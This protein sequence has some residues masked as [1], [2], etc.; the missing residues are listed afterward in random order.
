[1]RHRLVIFTLLALLTCVSGPVQAAPRD[2]GPVVEVTPI[3][4]PLEPFN[5]A[6]FNFNR[7]VDFIVIKPV[8]TVYKAVLPRFVRNSVTAF[9][10]NLGSP[11]ILMNELLQGDWR[12]FEYT[13]HRFVINSTLGIGGLIDVASYHGLP[14]TD[15][16]DFGQTLGVWGMDHGFYLVLPIIGPSSARDGVGRA[17]DVVADPFNQIW[18]DSETE[19]PIYTRAAL[20][21]ID[22]RARYGDKYEEIL[23]S[24]VDPYVTFRSI[25]AQ[26]RA[27]VVQDKGIDPYSAAEKQ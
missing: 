24:A 19:W 14:N 27:Y 25:Y 9:L 5:R 16:A 1:M 18:A 10:G 12:G 26:R 15:Y 4:D 20:T 21:V 6:V 23:R 2:S 8:T 22:K 3:P 11:V 17:V 7:F 13:L